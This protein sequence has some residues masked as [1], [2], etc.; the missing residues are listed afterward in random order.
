VTTFVAGRPRLEGVRV[1]ASDVLTAGDLTMR[2]GIPVTSPARTAMDVASSMSMYLLGRFVDHIRRERHCDIHE[3]A[4]VVNGLGGRG[5]PG[6]RLLRVLVEERLEGLE[7]GDSDAEVI[8]VRR[9]L[10]L[11]VPRPIQNH[12]VV[13]GRRV[14]FLDLAWPE[15]MI[16]VELDGFGPHSTRTAFDHDRERDLLLKRA[17][18]EILRVSTRTDLRLVADLILAR[19]ASTLQ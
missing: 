8:A 2:H 9:L 4:F 16:A 13:V 7:A 1:H 15:L 19:V 5:R 17:G 3:L 18:W 10:Q 12:E 14:F 11:G 6:T